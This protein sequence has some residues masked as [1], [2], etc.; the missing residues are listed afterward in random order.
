MRR[1]TR[2]HQKRNNQ[3][4]GPGGASLRQ[5]N[6]LVN[7]SPV[8][9][10]KYQ[11][12]ADVMEAY[13]ADPRTDEDEHIIAAAQEVTLRVGIANARRGA[14][15]ITPFK[16][17]DL[18]R[19]IDPFYVKQKGM[20]SNE[21]K[22]RNRWSKTRYTIKRV[23]AAIGEMSRYDLADDGKA[24]RTTMLILANVGCDAVH[25][26]AP[27]TPATEQLATMRAAL[28]AEYT[29]LMELAKDPTSRTFICPAGTQVAARRSV[30]RV[31]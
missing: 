14:A 16:E 15:H 11:T 13:L 8:R 2:A 4:Y 18:V 28:A 24:T 26:F 20:R 19:V 6:S 21:L 7:S 5:I 17:G 23:E 31:R 22:Q 29:A 12:P 9:E 25:G 1:W 10:L 30:D 27:G 3:W